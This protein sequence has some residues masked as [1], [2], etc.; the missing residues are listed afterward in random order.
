MSISRPMR[1]I[2]SILTFILFIVAAG[3]FYML[4]VKPLDAQI[5]SLEESIK[6]EEDVVKQ[7]ESGN[8][9]PIEE[10]VKN[11]TE[12]QK[13]VPV[14]DQIDQ[15]LLMLEEAEVVS[16]SLIRNADFE[17]STVDEN[18]ESIT[19]E[20]DIQNLEEDNKTF[21]EQTPKI[22][23]HTENGKA[24]GDETNSEVQK[25]AALPAGLKKLTANLTIE[26]DEY[27]EIK[28]FVKQ[29]EQFDRITNI[30]SLEFTGFEE[31]TNIDDYPEERQVLTYSMT[32][33]TYFYPSLE[34]LKDQAPKYEPED[35][36]DKDNPFYQQGEIP[37][38]ALIK[39]N[40]DN[41]PYE[42]VERDGTTYHVYE[43][44]VEKGD[45]LSSIADIFYQDGN[46]EA[47]IKSWNG[48]T[49]DKVKEG[50]K[51]EI[52]VEVNSTTETDN[53]HKDTDTNNNNEEIAKSEI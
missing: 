23:N 17:K 44:V 38:S 50:T 13:K 33:S 29:I 27:T 43:Y 20:E 31:I 8:Q 40:L 42:E 5:S 19:T 49:S 46:G 52:P 3:A 28:D 22:N 48:L 25:E 35:P 11:T 7:Y 21:N 1:I 18:G 12:L 2:L 30:D 14:I 41:L 6:V 45:T 39:R 36:A 47:L 51:L 37:R 32:V 4:K 10:E 53:N 9:E 24:A 15:F 34:E 26:A 16:G